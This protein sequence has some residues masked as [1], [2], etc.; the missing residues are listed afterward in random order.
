EEIRILQEKLR[1]YGYGVEPSG[2][3]DEMTKVVVAAFQRHFRRDLID[4]IADRST[5]SV[6]ERLLA[7]VGSAA[8]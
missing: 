1:A 5:C 2:A 8:V 3:Y 4:G 6:L 7:K